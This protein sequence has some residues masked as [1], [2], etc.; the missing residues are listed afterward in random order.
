MKRSSMVFFLG[1]LATG[2]SAAGRG[3]NGSTSPAANAG[4]MIRREILCATSV[5]R[6]LQRTG[7]ETGA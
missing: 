3:R 6:S 5:R 4:S 7:P 2:V 1:L